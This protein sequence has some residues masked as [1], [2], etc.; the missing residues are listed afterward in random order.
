MPG[1]VDTEVDEVGTGADP[2]PV[3]HDQGGKVQGKAGDHKDP[4]QELK[5][6]INTMEQRLWKAGLLK[7]PKE[8]SR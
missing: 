4:V 6:R 2:D 1:D 7:N 8:E 5:A 3:P